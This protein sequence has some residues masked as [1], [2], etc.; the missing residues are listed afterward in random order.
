MIHYR[1]RWAVVTGASSGFGRGIAVR[2]AQQGMF[3]VLTG[4]NHGRLEETANQ[5]RSAA[6]GSKVETVVA[7]LSIARACP[8]WSSASLIAMRPKR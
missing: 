8:R 1:D 6:P 5:V 2:L 3:L 4:R 7:D